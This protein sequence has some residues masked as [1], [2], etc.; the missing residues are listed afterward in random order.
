MQSLVFFINCNYE[1]NFKRITSA[2][3]G[4]LTAAIFLLLFIIV[5]RR[6]PTLGQITLRQPAQPANSRS[7]FKQINK[8]TGKSTH[9]IWRK[10]L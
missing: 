2:A 6:T 1:S 10:N 3:P 8:N 7:T 9:A 5:I 4:I